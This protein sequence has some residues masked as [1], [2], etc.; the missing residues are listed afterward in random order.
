V[1]GVGT[2]LV[3]L[4]DAKSKYLVFRGRAEDEFS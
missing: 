3:L 4:F 2:L 1:F